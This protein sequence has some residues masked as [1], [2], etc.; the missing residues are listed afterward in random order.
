MFLPSAGSGGS[1]ENVFVAGRVTCILGTLAHSFEIKNVTYQIPDFPNLC[2]DKQ[3]AV[4]KGLEQNLC[5]LACDF[6]F[7]GGHDGRR[8][9]G[10]W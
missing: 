2:D 3:N 10:K 6:T 1:G 5:W 8:R 7:E 4:C 9:L